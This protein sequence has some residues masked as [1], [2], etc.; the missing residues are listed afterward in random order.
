MSEVEDKTGYVT[1]LVYIEETVQDE[2]YSSCSVNLP[3]SKQTRS[4]LGSVGQKLFF[5]P[6]LN[7]PIIVSC[8]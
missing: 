7:C 1:A 4:E 6:T 3:I 5:L 8:H 2:L